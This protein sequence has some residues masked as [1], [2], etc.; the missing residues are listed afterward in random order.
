MNR[1]LVILVAVVASAAASCDQAFYPMVAENTVAPQAST[2][3]VEPFASRSA[4]PVA[5]AADPNAEA[6]VVYKRALTATSNTEVYRGTATSYSDPAS[7]GTI[8]AYSLAKVRGDKTFAIGGYAYGAWDSD[9]LRDPNGANDTQQTALPMGTSTISDRIF[10]YAGADALTGQQV[11]LADKDWYSVTLGPRL[12]VYFS[13]VFE[14]TTQAGLL[15]V[16]TTT[17]IVPSSNTE[18]SVFNSTDVD[19]TIWFNVHYNTA[20]ASTTTRDRVDYQLQ[21]LRITSY[22]PTN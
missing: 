22:N 17:D 13:V 11:T 19:Q 3:T 18:L 14:D 7:A 5:W 20:R 4:N 12:R 21:F 6:Y 2:P 15:E 8:Y 10:Y 1:P 9:Y 16:S